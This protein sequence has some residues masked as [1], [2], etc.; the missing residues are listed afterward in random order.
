MISHSQTLPA[1][2]FNSKNNNLSRG[3][4]LGARIVF[5]QPQPPKSEYLQNSQ[6]H[7][8]I[9]ISTNDLEIRLER[10]IDF[11]PDLMHSQKRM[12][13][14]V[15]IS[16][17]DDNR[18]EMLY[19]IIKKV[20]ELEQQYEKH[21]KD[22]D[23]V[24]E[25]IKTN[26]TRKVYAEIQ[27]TPVLSSNVSHS[28]AMNTDLPSRS[29]ARS[30]SN[31]RRSKS[32][33]LS[34]QGNTCFINS[35]LQMIV[36]LPI[37]MSLFSG[38]TYLHI[39]LFK[40]LKGMREQKVNEVDKL[41]REFLII[42]NNHSDFE[43]GCQSDPKWLIMF[44]FNLCPDVITWKRKVRFKHTET[45]FKGTSHRVDYPEQT[46]KIFQVNGKP[47]RDYKLQ[48]EE[49]LRSTFFKV[50]RKIVNG[51]CDKCNR[52]AHGTE[53]I[54]SIVKAKVLIFSF[55]FSQ[56]GISIPIASIERIFAN[57][58]AYELYCI[59]KRIGS[60]KEYGHNYC[61]C[62]EDEGWIE[63]YD[64]C[65]QRITSREIDNCYILIYAQV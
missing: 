64:S 8:L 2:A 38:H 21:R 63:Y 26:E 14:K 17:D 46:F 55:S 42:L 52:E 41:M 58:C 65:K 28:S 59:I 27:D 53:T 9:L 36:H 4:L 5:E 23:R 45:G 49:T 6:L 10:L 30:E 19:K 54:T 22:K 16:K 34:N 57:H 43:R 7:K 12:L 24:T 60:T 61:V 33:G 35:V 56:N 51:Y 29:Q 3:R 1:S 25:E 47:V 20:Q 48:L 32:V 40:V 11:D 62:K 18:I 15:K 44:L 31:S 39:N 50:D 37:E 13:D